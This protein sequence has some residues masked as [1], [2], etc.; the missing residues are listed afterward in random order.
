MIY[1]NAAE[2]ISTENLLEYIGV[3]GIVVYVVRK[4]IM[5]EKV[6]GKSIYMSD[7][8]LR[9]IVEVIMCEN[10]CVKSVYMNDVFLLYY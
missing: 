7:I 2:T 10:G 8:F 6:C 4:V 1:F 5:C 3:E 9:V